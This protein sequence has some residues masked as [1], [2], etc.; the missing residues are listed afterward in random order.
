MHLPLSEVK[1]LCFVAVGNLAELAV[2]TGRE[3]EVVIHTHI[4]GMQLSSATHH[5]SQDYPDD[6]CRRDRVLWGQLR[7]MREGSAVQTH[8]ERT[9]QRQVK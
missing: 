6:F 2:L 3:V 8:V 5:Q 1:C 4:T 7:T 9:N